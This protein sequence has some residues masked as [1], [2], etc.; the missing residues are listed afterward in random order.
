MV[1]YTDGSGIN[2]GIG[3]GIYSPTTN[4]YQG[5]HLGTDKSTN[6]YAAEL[7]AINMAVTYAKETA[8]HFNRCFIFTDNQATIMSISQPK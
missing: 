3:A 5:Q 4:K 8:Q 6:V 1:I 2:N 7:T